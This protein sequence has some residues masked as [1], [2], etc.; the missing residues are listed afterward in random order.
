MEKLLHFAV[1][2]LFGDGTMSGEPVPLIFLNC[3]S[4]FIFGKDEK[5]AS[6]P[7]EN[8]T[9][10]CYLL[11]E[12]HR[13]KEF[14]TYFLAILPIILSVIACLLNIGYL[15]AQLKCFS[16]EKTSFK[17]R[18]VFLISR[19]LSIILANLLFYVVV[20]VWKA[21]GFMYTSAM[22]F[23]LIGGVNFLS[24]TGTY[25]GLTILLYT[26]IAH[27]FWYM[28]KLTL[29]HCWLIIGLI[30][31]L[32]TASSVCI[33]L[34]GATLFYPESA[35]IS[36]S[37]GSCQQPLAIIIVVGLSICY[38]TVI[39]LYIAMM[40]RLHR[41]VRKSSMVQSRSKSNSMTAMKRLG[42]NMITFA[43]GS[44]PILI[45]CIVAL[46]NLRELS[47]LGEGCKSPCKTFLHSS[48][49]V[50]VEILASVAAIVWIIAMIIDPVINI[51]ADKKLRGLFAKQI[52]R[53]SQRIRRA[54]TKS[55]ISTD[56][57]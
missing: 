12:V 55:T 4:I 23:I 56:D 25:I 15:I 7:I 17:K 26:A 16:Q 50:E 52:T 3:S 8:G 9:D 10:P 47:S 20:I 18:Q 28:T 1:H 33:G 43:I 19:S 35:P 21:N 11:K 22:I 38:G 6:C 29:T 37:F 41:L 36:C 51:L 27:Q 34:W 13:A 14:R 49:F 2:F 39:G 44:V 45:V 31:I 57:Q 48:L 40:A 32:S 53:V 46:V 30:W 24:V 42:L 54:S 5:Y